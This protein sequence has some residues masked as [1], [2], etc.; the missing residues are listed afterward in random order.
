MAPIDFQSIP[1]VPQAQ[2]LVKLVIDR[3][4]RKIGVR[5]YRGGAIS[6]SLQ[7]ERDKLFFIRDELTERLSTIITEYPSIDSLPEFYRR[8][9]ATKASPDAAKKALGSLKFAQ[10]A[11]KTVTSEHIQ[12][13]KQTRNREDARAI[14][15]QFLGRTA[16]VIKQVGSGLRLLEE[17]RH[18]FR[19]FP[20][21]DPEAFT[22]AITGFPN[23]GK[24][25]LLS[26][27][28]TASPA[29]ANYAFTTK[30]LNMGTFEYRFSTIQVLDTPGT[31][32]RT[33]END[34]ELQAR[35]ARQ[36]LARLVVY[37]YDIT[38]PYPL[39][40]QE[41]LFSMVKKENDDVLIYLSKTD[42]L[43]KKQVAEF[44]EKHPGT[45]TSPDDVKTAVKK[46]F[47]AWT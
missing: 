27:I 37:V 33:S 26:K 15:R 18:A 16:S 20:S 22:V 29:I 13:L 34:V 23:V 6:R 35:I 21:I 14:T 8:L 45:L 28:T 7:A 17:T 31:L 43:P 4:A 47:S 32:A 40:D 42:M 3:A 5:K 36:Y 41:R 19:S 12:K 9:L 39:A 11:L 25:T 10:R 2:G 46:A 38:E 44:L 30:T 24:S 1:S